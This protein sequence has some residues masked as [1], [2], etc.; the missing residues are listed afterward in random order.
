M[1]GLIASQNSWHWAGCGKHPVARDYFRVGLT[2]PLVKAFFDWVE[3]GYKILGSKDRPSSELCSWRFWARGA[4]RETLVCGVGRD[5]S[6][7][8]GRPYPLLIMGTGPLEGWEDQWDL[9]P[10]ACEKT[11]SQMEYLST[12]KFADLRELE[13]QVRT[14]EP[15][16][17]N[18]SEFMS[19]RRNLGEHYSSSRD[20]ASSSDTRD[21]GK[22]IA[23]LSRSPL[24]S[25][26]LKSGPLDDPFTLAGVCHLLLK[27]V[28]SASMPNVV[29]WG[30]TPDETYLAV[31]KRPL[32]PDD[33][34]WLWSKLGA[35][36]QSE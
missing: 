10:F 16:Y 2:D 34:V 18:W 7:S 36:P 4:R 29:F 24:F 5:S 11:W 9:L 21:L 8:L 17:P 14:V 20:M 1:L 3:K 12:K 27:E 25:V 23:N 6:D 19:E 32:M 30:G 31:F 26:P 35:T 13:Y 33:F 15:P 22:K 28:S